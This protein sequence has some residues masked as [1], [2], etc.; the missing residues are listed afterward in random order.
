M[1]SYGV[2]SQFTNI[3]LQETIGVCADSHY[4]SN[5]TLPPFPKNILVGQ[6][7]FALI[8]LY[9]ARSTGQDG[10]PL[11]PTLADIFVGF[12]ES[13][14]L[15]NTLNPPISFRYVDDTCAAFAFE[16]DV[17]IF[18]DILNFLNTSLSF[19]M[20]K[21]NEG[22]LPFLDVLIQRCKNSFLTTVCHKPTFIGAHFCLPLETYGLLRH[23]YKEPLEFV[24][25]TNSNTN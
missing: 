4:N 8:T 23:Q 5:L 24:L 14:L 13:T 20:E 19:T 22:C 12:Y 18:S 11:N 25:P 10:N 3:P 15:S 17:T 2:S 6:W 1:C 9:T 16:I 21:E 7:N